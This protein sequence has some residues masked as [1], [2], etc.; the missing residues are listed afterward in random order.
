M[1]NYM[2]SEY[3]R[4][5]R[6]KGLHLTGI[7]C[8]LLIASAAGV[9]YFTAQ[10][11]PNFRYGTSTFF[12]SNVIAS[13]L[14][15][16]I[17]G[18][19]YNIALT[20]KDRYLIKQAISFGISRR[21]I[22]WSKL[23]LT[24]SYFLFICIVGIC[25]MI[26]LGDNLLTHEHHAIRHFLMASVNMIPI[27]LSGF[28]LV[29]TLKMLKVGE[30]FI[31]IIVSIIFGFLG[32]LLHLLLRPFTALDELYKYAPDTMLNDNLMSFV[33]DTPELGFQY[34][35]VGLVISGVSLL[36]GAKLFAKQNID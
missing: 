9:L 14:L 4:L 30:I 7:I 31:I 36:I 24:L 2:K 22:F 8:F 15:I 11:D 26:L 33:N 23:I 12:Y 10:S 28:F 13:G 21:I 35:I 18:L 27:V 17:I 6:K 32:D 19:L 5:L 1:I 20:G 25:L 16:I 3:Y 29:H 34:W